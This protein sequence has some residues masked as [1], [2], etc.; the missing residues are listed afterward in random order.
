LILLVVDDVPISTD[1]AIEARLLAQSGV[2]DR[3]PES[4][5]TVE[6]AE[7]YELVVISPSADSDGIGGSLRDITV[8]MLLLE[9][10]VA[11]AQG[12]GSLS[13]SEGDG[14]AVIAL[15]SHPMAGGTTGVVQLCSSPVALPGNTILPSGTSVAVASLTPGVSILFAYDAGADVGGPLPAARAGLGVFRLAAC[16]TDNAWRYFDLAVRWLLPN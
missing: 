2:V 9:P 6:L 14:E 15:E 4:A 7:N 5:V 3:I 8:P 12:L 11:A 16:Q 1:D 13:A 10:S